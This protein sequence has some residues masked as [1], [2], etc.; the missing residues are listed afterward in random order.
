[1][2][3]SVAAAWAQA[4]LSAAAIVFSSVFAVL[5]PA[6]ERR[7]KAREEN[8]RRLNVTTLRSPPAG[9]RLEIEYLPEFTHV[10]LNARVALKSP[11][12]A[13]V[14][15][16]RQE[17]NPAQ[18]GGDYIRHVLD[19]PALGNIATTRL[20][21]LDNEQPFSGVLLLLPADDAPISP[22]ST[23]SRAKLLVE[24][25]TDAGEILLKT[26]LTVSPTD[27]RHPLVSD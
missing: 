18:I 27:E 26:P 6:R 7:L 11:T 21:R 1:M 4:W 17:T 12:K 25:M 15:H 9:L 24:I 16:T 10:G 5:V 2:D 14:H 3:G 8:R 19:G 22:I 23:I 13:A 20:T